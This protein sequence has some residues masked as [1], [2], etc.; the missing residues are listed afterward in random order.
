MRRQGRKGELSNTRFVHYMDAENT[1]LAYTKT[2]MEE[3]RR[4]KKLNE[5]TSTIRRYYSHEEKKLEEPDR[6]SRGQRRTDYYLNSVINKCE[7]FLVAFVE[8]RMFPLLL[9]RATPECSQLK[10]KKLH[11]CDRPVDI[12]NLCGEGERKRR[13]PR[14]ARRFNVAR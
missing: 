12:V 4:E 3:N 6:E 10:T 9:C 5:I 2:M 8:E 11:D 7:V 13:N 14:G 1:S